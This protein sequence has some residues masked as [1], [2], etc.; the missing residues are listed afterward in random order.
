MCPP[1]LSFFGIRYN[2]YLINVFIIQHPNYFSTYANYKKII[3]IS[4]LLQFLPFDKRTDELFD[5]Y[6][7]LIEKAMQEISFWNLTEMLNKWALEIWKELKEKVE[8][9]EY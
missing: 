3:I 4:F 1:C 8:V 6:H 9:N 2:M 7:E 5:W